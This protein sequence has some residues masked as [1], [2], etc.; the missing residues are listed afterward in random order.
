MGKDTRPYYHE[1][2][3]AQVDQLIADKRTWQWVVENY[4]QPS[5]CEYPEALGGTMGCW[6]LTDPDIRIKISHEFC[7]DCPC[8]GRD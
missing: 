8:Y 1:L 5:W 6:S 4:Q 2:T 7:K 3:E